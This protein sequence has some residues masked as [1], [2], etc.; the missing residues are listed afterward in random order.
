[1]TDIKFDADGPI[2]DPDIRRLLAGF[3]GNSRFYRLCNIA[4]GYHQDGP[5]RTNMARAIIAKIDAEVVTDETITDAHIEALRLRHTDGQGKMRDTPIAETCWA[6]TYLEG[7][8]KDYRKARSACVGHVNTYTIESILSTPEAKLVLDPP[9]NAAWTSSLAAA[10]YPHGWGT[11]TYAED[12]PPQRGPLIVYIPDPTKRGTPRTAEQS[13]QLKARVRAAYPDI[14][15]DPE[16]RAK[17]FTCAAGEHA[18]PPI[19]HDQPVGKIERKPI[20]PNA[21]ITWY[22]AK[23][24]PDVRAALERRHFVT[25]MTIPKGVRVETDRGGIAIV[26]T[27]TE[28]TVSVDGVTTVHSPISAREAGI[29]VIG[30]PPVTSPERAEAKLDEAAHEHAQYKS[31]HKSHGRDTWAELKTAA[32]EYA[33]AQLAREAV[34]GQDALHDHARLPPER[35]IVTVEV[36]TVEQVRTIGDTLRKLGLR[37]EYDAAP[38]RVDGFDANHLRKENTRIGMTMIQQA[39]EIARLKRSIHLLS[40][41][42]PEVT[43]ACQ[44]L[45]GSMS[46]KTILGL[47]P[48]MVPRSKYTEALKTAE[49]YRRRIDARNADARRTVAAG[50]PLA[51]LGQS[52]ML[53]QG[54]ADDYSARTIAKTHADAKALDQDLQKAAIV[55]VAELAQAN[56]VDRSPWTIGEIA[57][58]RPVD[59]DGK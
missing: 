18:P 49:E 12:S 41:E 55:F 6:A 17:G 57:S 13:E 38:A 50:A 56:S 26:A 11:V 42:P 58:L 59:L 16:A 19:W 15:A 46:R 53:L 28:T 4:F 48:H 29:N 5:A 36:T 43:L 1:M 33:R 27:S 8:P 39:E 24:K 20:D 32:L 35:G 34:T 40:H 30:I 52:L 7:P 31:V 54:K 47:L 45:H 21:E 23:G 10:A 14:V 9:E 22:D 25:E 51:N 37:A 2:G 44:G 3:G